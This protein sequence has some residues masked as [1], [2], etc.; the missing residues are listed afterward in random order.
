MRSPNSELT[1]YCTSADPAPISRTPKVSGFSFVDA[2]PTPAAASLPP[3]ALQ[4]L[5]SWGVIEST[6][7]TLRSS[8]EDHAPGP[9]NIRD[10]SRR[11]RLANEMARKAKRSLADRAGEGGGSARKSGLAVGGLRRS[12]L[13]SVRS[14]AGTPGRGGS[15]GTPGSPRSSAGDLSPAASA[16]LGRTGQGRALATG[17]AKTR[18]W[19]EDEERRRV[20]RAQQRAREVESRERLRRE[21]WTASPAVSLG[22]DPEEDKH[23]K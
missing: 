7:V 18:G 1:L 22:F 13:D 4:E 21:R 8:G 10:T 20:E 2:L 14:G 9:F 16:L 12:V 23:K 5:M 3:Q 6:P 19:G 11:E 17:L 15:P